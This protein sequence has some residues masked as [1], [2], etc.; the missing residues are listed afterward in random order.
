MALVLAL[1]MLV[2]LAITVIGIIEYTGSNSRAAEVNHGRQD[3]SSIAEAGVNA[4]YSVLNYWDTGTNTGNN[5][6]D[7]QLLGCNAAGVCTP[8]CVSVVVQCPSANAVGVEGT[9]SYQGTYDPVKA[10]WSITS[11]GYARNPTGAATIKKTI[12]ATSAIVA[13]INNPANISAWNHL[14]STAP[15]GAGCEVDI[16]NNNVYIDTPA[17]V[18]GDLCFSGMYDRIWEQPGGQPVDLRV[19]GKLVLAGAN[20]SVGYKDPWNNVFPITSAEI[21]QG[22]STTAAGSPVPCTNPPFSWWVRN[23]GPFVPVTP[24]EVTNA[25]ADNMYNNA[26]PGPKHPCK[27]GTSP[28]GLPATT[29]ESTGNTARDNSVATVFNLTPAYSYSCQSATGTGAL[30]WDDTTNQLTISGIVYIDG[31]MQITQSGSY[32]GMGSIY[33]SGSFTMGGY[34]LAFCAVPSCVFGHWDPNTRMLMIVALGSGTAINISGGLDIFQG[35]LFANPGSTTALN[36]A[37]AYVQG[38][39]VSGKFQFNQYT[40][41][42]PLP[43]INKLPPGAPLAVNARATPQTPIITSG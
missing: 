3:A 26:D 28:A 8:R 7:S 40:L 2:T 22:C 29:F 24:P 43:T 38:P 36:G 20:T 41:I 5:A 10:I 35:S 15:Q 9:A 19:G 17:Y 30:T 37:S 23:T 13:D 27:A 31:S 1:G 33:L 25:D 21:A 12:N 32:T 16:T 18:T 42:Q 14:Y 4:A 34:A 39:L 11:T 6:T